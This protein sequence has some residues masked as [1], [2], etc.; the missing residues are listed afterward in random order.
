MSSDPV[1]R[2]IRL[3]KLVLKPV[4]NGY[5]I[6]QSEKAF[7]DPGLES[8][9][10]EHREAITEELLRRV[11]PLQPLRISTVE[12]IDPWRHASAGL[13]RMS[14][15]AALLKRWKA[16]GY[17]PRVSWGPP[18]QI[19]DETDSEVLH[20]PSYLL[21]EVLWLLKDPPTVAH[22]CWSS[23]VRPAGGAA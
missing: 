12:D 20:V 10:A 19:V 1:S 18:I 7:R 6:A 23:G 5:C 15:A 17:R 13:D 16:D 3:H 9:I 21:I 11:I 8:K 4:A 2:L 14:H 22:T